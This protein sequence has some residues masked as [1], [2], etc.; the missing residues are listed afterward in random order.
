[1]KQWIANQYYNFMYGLGQKALLKKITF[2]ARISF[3]PKG[4]SIGL[5][6][7]QLRLDCEPQ[8]E[9]NLKARED[10]FPKH[11]DKLLGKVEDYIKETGF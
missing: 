5:A 1:M 4:T 11:K 6:F 8:I 7:L 3:F 2:L 9:H 10:C